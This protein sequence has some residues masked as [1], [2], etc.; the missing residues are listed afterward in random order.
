MPLVKLLH[1]VTFFYFLALGLTTPIL[2]LYL[3]K[4]G[5]GPVWIGWAIALMPLAGI[6]LRPITG[7]ASDAWSRKWPIVHTL[8][9]LHILG[10]RL[11][12][13]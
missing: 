8:F 2:P 4:M 5:I 10:L 1:V 13:L 9:E 11:L 6:V 7:W 12:W 3:D